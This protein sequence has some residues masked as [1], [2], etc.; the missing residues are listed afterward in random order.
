MPE[1]AIRRVVTG[2]DGQGRSCVL[3]DG[4]VPRASPVATLVWRNAAI[5]ADNSGTEDAGGP[6][7]MEQLH[8]GGV[9]FILTEMPPGESGEAFMHAT[10]TIDYLAV[11]SGEITMVLETGEVVLRAGDLIVDRGVIHGW[12]N[13]GADMAVMV[14]VTVP[15]H[16]VGKGRTV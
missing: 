4:E 8:D 14:S 5:P 6:Y 10:D 11:I 3:I 1:T 7:E 2:L 12:R 15:A 13:D 9:N 16:P